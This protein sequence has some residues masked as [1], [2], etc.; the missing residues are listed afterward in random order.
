MTWSMQRTQQKYS[1]VDFTSS[2]K[3]VCISS[4]WPVNLEDEFTVCLDLQRRFCVETR[5]VVANRK[6]IFDKN[7]RSF[8][9]KR[10]VMQGN[11]SCYILL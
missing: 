7:F 10:I 3:S 11:V 9:G 5:F 1:L 2:L 4:W 8:S 6:I